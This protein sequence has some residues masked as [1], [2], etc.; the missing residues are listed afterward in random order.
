MAYINLTQIF[1]CLTKKGDI[2][3]LHFDYKFTLMRIIIIK[4]FDQTYSLV[5][6]NLNFV[7]NCYSIALVQ[8]FHKIF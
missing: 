2:L 8:H 4:L 3:Y 1:K 5:F 7:S 6:F